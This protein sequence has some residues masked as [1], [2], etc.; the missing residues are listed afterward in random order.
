[1]K[2]LVL[3]CI[4]MVLMF[5][6]EDYDGEYTVC[7]AGRTGNRRLIKKRLGDL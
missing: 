1:M 6:A 7:S 4:G 3:V 5:L 2:I